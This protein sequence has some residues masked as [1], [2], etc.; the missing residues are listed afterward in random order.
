MCT[1][2]Q[3]YILCLIVIRSFN[4]T[5]NILVI[6]KINC[7]TFWHRASLSRLAIIFCWATRILAAGKSNLQLLYVYVP[8]LNDIDDYTVDFA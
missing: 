7:R 1:Y 2:I 5:K 3:G 6:F 4:L 8:H